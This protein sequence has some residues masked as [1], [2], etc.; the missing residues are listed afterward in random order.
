MAVL[1]I[2]TDNDNH[3]LNA[4]ALAAAVDVIASAQEYGGPVSVHRAWVE[5]EDVEPSTI[6]VVPTRGMGRK[7]DPR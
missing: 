5:I 6:E 2:A 7:F 4:K 1:K 3:E